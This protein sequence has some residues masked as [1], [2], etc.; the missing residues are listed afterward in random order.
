MEAARK[1]DGITLSSE[2]MRALK[3]ALQAKVTV[4]TGGPG[5][6]KTTLLRSLLVALDSAGLKP[7]LAAPT[8]R[9]ARRLAEASGRE[10]KT[11]HRLLEYSPETNEFLRSERFPLR[12]NFLIVDEASMM[13]V[14]LAASLVRALIP[15]R[16]AAAGRRSRSVAFGGSR[17]R[18]QGRHRIAAGAGGGIAGGLSA[19]AREPDRRQRA[20]AESRRDADY[21]ERRG[22]RFLFLR[23]RRRQRTC[24]ARS[25]SWC[26]IAWWDASESPIRAKSRC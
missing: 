18:A 8:G 15:G 24:S 26:R 14:E 5:T 23:A 7:T 20:S 1:T 21:A 4:I 25:S 2:Q 11:I 19:G 13:D 17:Q 6:G 9:A 12:T 16:V 10:A 22:G 3:T